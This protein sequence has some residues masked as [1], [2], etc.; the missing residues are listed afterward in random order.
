MCF[1]VSRKKKKVE[2]V[3]EI[4]EKILPKPKFRVFDYLYADCF[5]MHCN[6][7]E[8]AEIF[9]NTIGEQGWISYHGTPQWE[10]FKEQTC[11]NF[12]LGT[13]G[14]KDR[15]E[16]TNLWEILEFD[17]FDWEEECDNDSNWWDEV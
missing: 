2:K 4:E 12:V 3:E 17:D 14:E 16:K 8:K 11:Y 9:I 6:T 15:Y 10:L 7:K 5:V 13:I 1:F